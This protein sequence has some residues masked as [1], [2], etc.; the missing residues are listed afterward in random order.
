MKIKK[1]VT[2]L[3]VLTLTAGLFLGI[4]AVKPKDVYAY[5][6]VSSITDF[7][8]YAS[9]YG[10]NAMETRSNKDGRLY[11]YDELLSEAKSFWTNQTDLSEKS[12]NQYV[13]ARID[14]SAYSLSPDD[15][16]E[17]YYAFQNDNP[18]F[19]FASNTLSIEG[20]EVLFLAD[21][22]YRTASAR[23][24]CVSYII[25]GINEFGKLMD[26]QNTSSKKT[27]AVY[28]KL[29]D[30]INY[31]Y[32]SDGTTPSDETWAHNIMG[33][34]DTSISKGV[35]E[36]YANVMHLA[37]N[38]AGI[39]NYFVSGTAYT[40]N[41][42]EA[43]AW[44]LV[45]F[46]DGKYYYLDATW[47]DGN[48]SY[49]Y[50]GKG[51]SF[52]GD[53][54]AN[55]SYETGAL[56]QCDMP[57][58]ASSDFVFPVS[59]NISSIADF[60]KIS[61]NPSATY[62][63][64]SNL[65]FS[66]ITALKSDDCILDMTFTGTLNGGGYTIS[67]IT[68]SLFREI[69]TGATV[70]NLKL[71]ADFGSNAWKSKKDYYS[72]F[73]FTLA[74]FNKGTI[75][76]CDLSYSL[77]ECSYDMSGIA[78]GGFVYTNNGTINSCDT[79][80]T[81]NNFT[82][83]KNIVLQFA[84][85]TAFNY[86]SVKNC[87]ATIKVNT[88]CNYL[89][90][91]N[92]S[93]IVNSSEG[94]IIDNCTTSG[95]VNTNAKGSMGFGG[96]VNNNFEGTVSN[97]TNNC[98]I[99]ISTG[100][101]LASAGIVVS[102]GGTIKN[103]TNNG[104]LY[105]RYNEIMETNSRELGG[106]C[107][108]NSGTIT[109][110]TNTGDITVEIGAGG[111]IFATVHGNST[112]DNCSNSGNITGIYKST[113]MI[114]IGGIGGEISFNSG[115]S[116]DENGNLI[117]DA[118]S[119]TVKN[120]SNSGTIKADY[121]AGCIVGEVGLIAKGSTATISSCTNTGRCNNDGKLGIN[122]YYQFVPG[123]NPES[124]LS[125]SGI[126]GLVNEEVFDSEPL[127]DDGSET[128]TTKKPNKPNNNGTTT[129]KPNNNNT[130]GNDTETTVNGE[131]NTSSGEE[132]TT[133][134][135]ENVTDPSDSTNNNDATN[136]GGNSDN[137]NADNNSTDNKGADNGNNKVTTTDKNSG[138]KKDDSGF[139]PIIIIIIVVATVAI[140]CGVSAFVVIRKKPA[141]GTEE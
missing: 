102:N 58:A 52:K 86:S 38:M 79:S 135:G 110:C 75:K 112:V 41:G 67:G 44:N 78:I 50:F 99:D 9:T 47:D 85:I 26:S 106:I 25:D 57:E 140:I 15:I 63:L 82:Y 62:T 12:G 114:T 84:G 60:K 34:F 94:G 36:C 61:L 35:C 119:C 29:M 4:S 117:Y 72:P 88:N 22:D 53:H 23:N 130:T 81:V 139:N 105:N 6:S 121:G 113:W 40:S 111:G 96:I 100:D 101:S 17:T 109:G 7:S 137:N 76:D 103:C 127:P 11:L 27:L 118:G 122:L 39:E 126:T 93:G 116:F 80:L 1:F 115:S 128:T 91:N 90:F 97:C 8:T 133:V 31:A 120:S 19:Y 59:G 46:E 2:L 37:L 74:E 125:V 71:K 104:V 92:L 24:K 66:K 51:I 89:W 73:K 98:N 55:P 124:N 14:T 134:N 141:T 138:N 123:S 45:K 30:K 33:Y 43:H 132:T 5:T 83:K 10:R 65:D 21:S 48:N 49:L 77:N 70:S 20:A 56:Y 95:S 107:G 18:I 108:C 32:K 54:N 87:N 69:A 3:S 28:D 131:S 16:V 129:T 136:N 68:F 64:K 42:S 13:I